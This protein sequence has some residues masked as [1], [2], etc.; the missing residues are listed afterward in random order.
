MKINAPCI[1]T[2]R[3]MPGIRIVD[4]FLSIEYRGKSHDGRQVYRVSLDT[5][6][7]EYEDTSIQSGVGGGT[8]A[9][10]L[11]SC[12]DFMSSCAESLAYGERTGRKGENSDL[13]PPKVA[14]WC[15]DNSDAI[16]LAAM[17]L[18]ESPNAIEE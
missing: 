2:P 11:H 3:L 12:L 10:G 6:D 15:R 5:P 17:E 4:A 14:E 9:Q 7:F 18:E 16:D 13:F 8:L 1:I